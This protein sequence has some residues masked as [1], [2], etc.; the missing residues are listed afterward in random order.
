MEEDGAAWRG[1]LRAHLTASI[2]QPLR[3]GDLVEAYADRIPLHLAARLWRF[4]NGKAQGEREL[5][6]PKHMRRAAFL[7]TLGTYKGIEWT[8]ARFH[9]RLVADHAVIVPVG[10]PCI[11]CGK[12]YIQKDAARYCG[13]QCA[14][15][16]RDRKR[17]GR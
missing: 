12:L 1:A 8:P 2:G 7:T 5:S 16:H 3:V 11:R 14:A 17:A 9:G 10:R 15:R 4:R 6:G 13:R